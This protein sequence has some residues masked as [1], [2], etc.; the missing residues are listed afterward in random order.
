MM[1][2]KSFLSFLQLACFIWLGTA[3]ALQN[4]KTT[5]GQ[6][7][8]DFLAQSVSVSSGAFVGLYHA[9]NANAAPNLV[10]YSSDSGNQFQYADAKL[11]EGE[12]KK[13]GDTVKI[14]YVLSSTGLSN[15][16]KIYSTADP[17]G[18]PY[19]WVLGDQ[20][21]IVGLEQAVAGGDGVP[22]MLPGGIRRVIIQSGGGGYN[23]KECSAGSDGSNSGPGPIPPGETYNR[24]KNTFCNPTR[25]DAPELVLDIKLLE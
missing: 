20:S 24:F 9:P 17:G 8:R 10:F 25:P 14:N 21:T 23:V 22:A 19:Q 3:E 18:V 16:V 13:A 15:G 7:R 4:T 5:M 12:P 2:R 1:I 11:G 6:Q